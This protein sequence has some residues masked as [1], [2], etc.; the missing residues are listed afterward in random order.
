MQ[1]GT[2]TDGGL[3][4]LLKACPKLDPTRL[5]REAPVGDASIQAVAVNFPGLSSLDLDNS[6]VTAHG[7]RTIAE[8]FSK[9]TDLSLPIG[10]EGFDDE[11]LMKLAVGCPCLKSL[12]LPDE[13]EV[14]DAGL[15][16]AWALWPDLLP[17]NLRGAEV[18]DEFIKA[19]A[20]RF[21]RLQALDL[22]G[23]HRTAF[24][25]SMVATIASQFPELK[26][27]NLHTNNRENGSK[28]TD[29]HLAAIAAGCPKLLRIYVSGNQVTDAGKSTA[30]LDHPQLSVITEVD[31]GS[32]D[33]FN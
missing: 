32:I 4:E 18:G 16:N 11:L 30:E 12:H 20:T 24:T 7:I 6:D 19:V 17:Q 10:A 31:Y 9:L 15:V 28:L 33:F 3:A 27:L 5:V 14:T 1:C 8:N 23:N 21:P 29:V 22:T 2:V 26:H 13:G 25:D